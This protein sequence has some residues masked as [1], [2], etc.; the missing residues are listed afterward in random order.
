MRSLRRSALALLLALLPPLAALPPASAQVG[1]APAP[2]PGEPKMV[3]LVRH[4]EKAP[5]TS[6]AP[7]DPNLSA[8]GAARA[9]A[10][11]QALEGMKVTAIVTT[12]LQ[13]TGQTAA[14][15]ARALG[16]TPEVVKIEKGE[17]IPAHAAKVAAAVRRHPGGVVLVVGHSNTVTPILAALGGPILPDLPDGEYGNLFVLTPD[18]S[19]GPARLARSKYG[20]PDGEGAAPGGAM[21]PAAPAGA[22]HEIENAKLGFR[23]SLPVFS[24]A[25]AAALRISEE[26]EASAKGG[27]RVRIQNYTG[28]ELAP[29][30]VPSLRKDQF[31]V[32]I[33]IYTGEAPSE[34]QLRSAC[35]GEVFAL[36]GG[37]TGGW[38]RFDD[39]KG[40][41]EGSA[42]HIG[43][44][45]REGKLYQTW[46]N[47]GQLP[48][49]AAERI[50]ESLRT[51]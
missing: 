31:W 50:F 21:P 37:A 35:A 16:L 11:A 36:E 1:G 28:D 2:A 24:P 3:I 6:D 12:H 17:A 15:L 9:A 34:S 45:L 5:E 32:E 4:A 25:L 48:P 22:W 27:A 26:T 29:G 7:G 47:A 19:G 13:R 10:L 14:P 44:L 33:R 20:A 38:C 42:T 43:W 49:G 39:R 46:M 40:E 30:E 8:A 41:G 51:P 18:P 23:V